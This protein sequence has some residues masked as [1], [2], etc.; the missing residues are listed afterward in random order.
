MSDYQDIDIYDC[1][2]PDELDDIIEIS[3]NNNEC[4]T[5]STGRNTFISSSDTFIYVL[6]YS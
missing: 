3:D 5:L 6:L 2:T 1:N 4:I